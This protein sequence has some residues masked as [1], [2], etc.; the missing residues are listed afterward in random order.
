MRYR[1]VTHG[2]RNVV[3]VEKTKG[4]RDKMEGNAET[5]RTKRTRFCCAVTGTNDMCSQIPP[6]NHKMKTPNNET[7]VGTNNKMQSAEDMGKAFMDMANLVENSLDTASAAKKAKPDPVAKE[8][9]R[10]VRA[11]VF[12]K[13]N[14]CVWKLRTLR[15]KHPVM[16]PRFPSYTPRTR[17][18]PRVSVL[19]SPH[20]TPLHNLLLPP[21][22]LPK[23]KSSGGQRHC[24]LEPP[25]SNAAA[26][27]R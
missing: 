13:S 15:S 4:K 9:K 24:C 18:H 20:E 17:N 8:D 11:G 3:L 27:F 22:Q 2:G 26:V 1:H 5:Q 21:R 23:S 19:C 6:P 12:C 7:I 25:L 16:F 14:L 10:S